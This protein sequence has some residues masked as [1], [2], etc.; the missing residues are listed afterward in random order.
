MNFSPPSFTF[1]NFEAVTKIAF[2]KFDFL[3]YAVCE[4]E[5]S[6]PWVNVLAK[7]VIKPKEALNMIES[8]QANIIDEV[9]FNSLSGREL[10]IVVNGKFHF[11]PEELTCGSGF[12][13]DYAHDFG[14]TIEEM[15]QEYEL[16]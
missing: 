4:V 2:A 9:L 7:K 13:E 15:K 10:R 16:T 6:V 14:I 11:T 12:E 1:S 8:L 5:D 3:E